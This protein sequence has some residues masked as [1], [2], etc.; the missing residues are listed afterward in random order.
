LAKEKKAEEAMKEAKEAFNQAF[1]REK[2]CALLELLIT[3]I[4]PFQNQDKAKEVLG[5]YARLLEGKQFV[6]QGRLVM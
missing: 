3:L 5:V 1:E 6:Y 2:V 4:H